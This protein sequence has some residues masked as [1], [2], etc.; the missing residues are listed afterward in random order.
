MSDIP[1]PT[2]RAMLIEI[3]KARLWEQERRLIE[4]AREAMRSRRPGRRRDGNR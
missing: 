3:A 4:A 1:C 2:W